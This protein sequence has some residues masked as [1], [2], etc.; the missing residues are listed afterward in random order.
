VSRGRVNIFS[1][2]HSICAGRTLLK[3]NAYLHE[4]LLI[5]DNDT[6]TKYAMIALTSSYY[7]EYLPDGSAQKERMKKW[8]VE[9]MTRAMAA[10]KRDAVEGLVF[11]GDTAKMLLIHHAI[12]NQNLHSAHW[13]NYLYQLQDFPGQQSN[14]IMARHSIW[15]MTILPLNEKYRFQTFNYD[16]VGCG[17]DNSSTKVNGI[18][19]TSRKMLYF[20][21][22]VTVAAKV[23]V[24]G[25]VRL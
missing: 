16:W 17:E 15:L 19:G 20:E 3:D 14:L 6:A 10:L 18:L 5:A 21:Y 24:T 9:A 2:V 22:L 25:R 8:E 11:S 23:S 1:D 4:V 12:L 7:K 13:T